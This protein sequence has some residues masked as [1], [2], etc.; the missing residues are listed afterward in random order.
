MDRDKLF[1]ESMRPIAGAL[2]LIMLVTACTANRPETV[3]YFEE[4][5]G[6]PLCPSA[7]V[8][9]FQVGKYDYEVDFTY[10]VRLKLSD[11]C[12]RDL[13]QQIRVRLKTVCDPSAACAFHD[14]NYWFYEL[15]PVENGS[16][17]FILRAT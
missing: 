7:E 4:V 13:L 2:L 11:L 9:N 5:T 3:E 8:Q 17:T 12:H 1:P 16:V 6:L 10:G 15:S 14:E